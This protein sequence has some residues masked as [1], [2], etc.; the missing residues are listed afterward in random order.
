MGDLKTSLSSAV[1]MP[2][3]S[4]FTFCAGLAT[5]MGPV[6]EV[7]VVVSLV[8]AVVLTRKL[9]VL[10]KLDIGGLGLGGAQMFFSSSAAFFW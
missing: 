10:V 7:D 6:V 2:G 4:N 3:R 9:F 8:P 1:P 5:W